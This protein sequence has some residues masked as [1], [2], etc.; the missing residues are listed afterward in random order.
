MG[1]TLYNT[2]NLNVSFVTLRLEMYYFK[3][4]LLD[5]SE[6]VGYERNSS[7]LHASFLN[8]FD[9]LVGWRKIC[10]NN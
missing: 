2:F 10:R 8:C 4:V 5:R 9:I 1:E 6:V 7:F 3:Q